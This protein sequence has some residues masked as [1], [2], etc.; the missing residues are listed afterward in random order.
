MKKYFFIAI[1][2]ATLSACHIV[3]SHEK[4]AQQVAEQAGLSAVAERRFDAS[5]INSN[6]D[7]SQYTGLIISELDLNSVKIISP[8]SPHSFDAPWVLNDN[9]KHFYQREY[10][11]AAQRHLLQSGLFSAATSAGKGVLILKSKIVDISPHA[12]KDDIKSRPMMMDI[13]SEGFGRM[14]IAIEIYDSQTHQLLFNASD[15]DDLGSLWEK[16]N[17]VQ[18]NQQIHFA[19]ERW[20]LS[21]K[22]QWETAIQK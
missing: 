8:S 20:M 5:F 22:K 15:E 21:L 3:K 19:F 10:L 16:N 14:T 7:F 12:P 1:F 13:Y 9:D 6:V 2:A 11:Q 17:R 18:N 4:S